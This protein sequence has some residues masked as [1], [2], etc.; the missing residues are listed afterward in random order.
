M[1]VQQRHNARYQSGETIIRY[2]FHPRYGE[3]VIVAGCRRHGE[4]VALIIRQPDGTMAH[5]PVWMTEDRAEAMMVTERPRL[6]LVHLRELRLELDAC[7]NLLRDDSC[8]EEGDKHETAPTP[9]APIGAL[10]T[11]D[12]TSTDSSARAEQA[13]AL[14]EC[15]AVGDPQCSRNDGG[16]R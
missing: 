9:S 7:L 4:E 11:Q 10:S 14:G 5:L 16:R 13:V 1:W 15:A 3:M 6:P 2:R 8:R 12:P